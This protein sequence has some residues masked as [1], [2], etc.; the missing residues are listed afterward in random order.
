[1]CLNE[2]AIRVRMPDACG[3]CSLGYAAIE[4]SA[5]PL[6]FVQDAIDHGEIQG[7]PLR[8]EDKERAIRI[9]KHLARAASH[10]CMY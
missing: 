9:A 5:D 1:M 7:V 2:D 3:H 6:V 8:E 4:E 10:V